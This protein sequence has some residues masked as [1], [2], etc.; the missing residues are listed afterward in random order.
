[1]SRL[2]PVRTRLIAAALFALSLAATTAR[3]QEVELAAPVEAVPTPVSQTV[4]PHSA[5]ASSLAAPVAPTADPEPESEIPSTPPDEITGH[6][7]LESGVAVMVEFNGPG[8]PLSGAGATQLAFPFADRAFFYLGIDASGSSGASAWVNER[9]WSTAG[10]TLGASLG[11]KLYLDAV[12]TGAV[13]PFVRLGGH[14]GGSESDSEAR[15][16]SDAVTVRGIATL[17]AS[18]AVADH[19]SIAAEA[20]VSGGYQHYWGTTQISSDG[21]TASYSGHEAL[22]AS[23]GRVFLVVRL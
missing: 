14:V 22:V 13:T 23:V 19:V 10:Y 8:V 21:E 7:E 18:W 9:A 12:R 5:Q 6:I 1:M 20:G 17:G 16:G 4:E 15:Y 3:A 2:D 11:V